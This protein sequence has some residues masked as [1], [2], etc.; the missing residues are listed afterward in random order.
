MISAEKFN[1]VPFSALLD[2]GF[3]ANRRV[4]WHFNIIFQTG[5]ADILHTGFLISP[6]LPDASSIDDVSLII[7]LSFFVAIMTSLIK[8]QILKKLSV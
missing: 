4:L 3:H 1:L 8:N 7:Y 2:L 6:L 5:T